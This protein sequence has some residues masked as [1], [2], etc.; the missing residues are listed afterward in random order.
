[1]IVIDADLVTARF[2][3]RFRIVWFTALS[4]PFE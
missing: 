3:A 1:V 4:R 2:S